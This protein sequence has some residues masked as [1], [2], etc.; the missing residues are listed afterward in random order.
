M[1][2]CLRF[3]DPIGRNN[4]F[5]FVP[6]LVFLRFDPKKIVLKRTKVVFLKLLWSSGIDSKEL[7]PTA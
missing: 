1:S 5:F 4:S 3:F 7:I 2:V 6:S